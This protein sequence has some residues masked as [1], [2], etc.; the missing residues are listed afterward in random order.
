MICLYY[1]FHTRNANSILPKTKKNRP[2]A[3]RLFFS[4]EG[5]DSD[6]LINYLTFI[7]SRKCVQSMSR[8]SKNDKKRT[9]FLMKILTETKINRKDW[10][11]KAGYDIIAQ[12]VKV[13][14]AAK[15]GGG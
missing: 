13:Y 10:K 12:D 4:Y 14:S 11:W 8:F 2:D 9:D 15:R 6:V 3:G 1:H 7:I 5:G